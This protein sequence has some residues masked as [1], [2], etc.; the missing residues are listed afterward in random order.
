MYDYN[1]D[2]KLQVDTESFRAH[3]DVL[4]NASDYFAAM[5]SHDMLEKQ[6]DTVA[7]HGISS[8]GFALMME[9]FYHGHITVD[10]ENIEDILESGCFFHIEWLTKI[11][12]D[13]LVRHMPLEHQTVMYLADKYC[14]GNLSKKILD[15]VSEKFVQLASNPSFMLIHYEVLYQLLSRD[16]YIHASEDFILKQVLRWLAYKEGERSEY[17]V[18]LLSLI[19]YSL[20]DVDDL[21]NLP[22]EVTSLESVRQ[23]VDEAI[24]F[25]SHPCRQCLVVS[26]KTEVRGSRDV[27][28]LITP[29]DEMEMV[30]YKVPGEEGYI[31]EESDTSFL[32]SVL[33]YASVAVLGNYLFVA[34]GYDRSSW[35]SSPA[36]Y[37]Y[38]PR[39]RSWAELS[40]MK[41]ARVSFCLCAGLK[42]LYAVTGVDH[43]V[44]DGRDKEIILDS[45]EFYSPE[46]N[47]WSFLPSMPFGCFSSAAAVLDDKLYVSGGISDDLEMTIPI[48]CLHVSVDGCDEWLPL[49]PM[50]HARQSHSM[51]A[52]DDQLLV[53]GGY[54]AGSDMTSFAHCLHC[55]AY[56]A[57]TDQWTRLDDAPRDYEHL[58][59][60][61]ARLGSSLYILGGSENNRL[62]VTYDITSREFVC[63]EVCGDFVLKIVVL[64]VAVPPQSLV[65]D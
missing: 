52:L 18:P 29:V 1:C 43:V 35:C 15:L 40:C 36:F 60:A 2:V 65:E 32:S 25:Q 54:M 20:L 3:R 44:D 57:A 27:V 51:T 16:D 8:R 5:F 13:F 48:N 31:S 64:S 62:L 38:N 53:F 12:C 30:Q 63:A 37:R 19:R 10:S 39:N 34:G 33:E 56:S 47:M 11:C 58:W 24:E 55:E 22:E 4:S 61:S 59:A 23:L 26:E 28:M 46:T 7:L 17:A 50:L 42:G 41:R 49:A 21:R 14:L 6:Q 45:I 9:Y